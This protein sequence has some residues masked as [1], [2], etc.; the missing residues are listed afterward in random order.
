VHWIPAL[1]VAGFAL[2]AAANGV[3]IW[4]ATASFSGLDSEHAYES[5]L[6]YNDALQASAKVA[7]LGWRVEIDVEETGGSP[8]LAL[9]LSDRDGRALA[10]L[11]IEGQLARPTLAS[12]DR[13]IAFR[14]VAPG[15]YRSPTLKGL[16]PGLWEARLVAIGTE[17]TWQATRRFVVK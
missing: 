15:A 1:F 9:R 12:L 7:S 3:L 11:T 2:V 4:F 8:A 5:G 14:E 10:G 13:D 17:P 16:Q 6:A